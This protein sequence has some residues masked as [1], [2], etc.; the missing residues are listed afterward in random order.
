MSDAWAMPVIRKNGRR[1][2][3]GRRTGETVSI[4]P[5]FVIVSQGNAWRGRVHSSA[6]AWVRWL[7][8]HE[9]SFVQ[10]W[11]GLQPWQQVKHRLDSRERHAGDGQRPYRE[12]KKLRLLQQR[13]CVNNDAQTAHAETTLNRK[14]WSWAASNPHAAHGCPKAKRWIWTPVGLQRPGWGGSGVCKS[15]RNLVGPPGFEPGTSCTPSKRA[16]QAAPRPE[17]FSV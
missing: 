6:A 3:R 8:G 5:V 16:S 7:Y 2:I 17:Q 13:T 1:S 4:W 14:A 9:R 10:R 11:N 15:L 12:N